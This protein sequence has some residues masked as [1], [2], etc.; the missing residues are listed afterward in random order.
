MNANKCILI[1][2]KPKWCELIALGKKTVEVRKTKPR[3]ET[4]FKCYIYCT[5]D[6]TFAEKTLR[7]FDENGKAIHYKA[8][9][10]KVIGEF[11]CD[12]IEPFLCMPSAVFSTIGTLEQT[13]LTAE[14]ISE[15]L[16]GKRGF[17]WHITDLVV[18]DKPRELCEFFQVK[19]IRGYHKKD[20]PKTDGINIPRLLNSTRFEVNFLT[21]PPQSWCY[22]E[23]GRRQA[24]D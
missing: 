16:S 5:K 14:Q 15:Y 19:A 24:A 9:K 1:S 20:E 2:I 17:G 6:N 21:R 12:N 11:V 23:H 22:V 8:N 4:P 18:Y 3:I 10:G 13:C 7:G